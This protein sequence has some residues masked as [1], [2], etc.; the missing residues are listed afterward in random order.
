[1]AAT[2]NRRDF[3]RFVALTAATA[4][5]LPQQVE[6]LTRYYERNTPLTFAPLVA[7]DEVMF[8]GLAQ[9][10]TVATIWFFRR[11]DFLMDLSINAF[12]GVL[13]WHAFADQKIVLPPADF[14][15]E[16][17]NRAAR[18]GEDKPAPFDSWLAGTVSYV[19]QT[20]L[21][22]VA[23]ITRPKGALS[24]ECAELA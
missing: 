19:D 5:A 13:R 14:R 6:A 18:D 11:D 3:V 10:S 24:D 21:R 16:I 8:S 22:R 17:V 12:G 1:M 20:G 2:M 7:V 23:R 9:Y 15:W 4:A